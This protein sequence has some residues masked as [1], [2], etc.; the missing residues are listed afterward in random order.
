MKVRTLAIVM[1]ALVIAGSATAQDRS[2]PI[3]ADDLAAI[4]DPQS[5][6]VLQADQIVAILHPVSTR[7]IV[8]DH[9]RAPGDWGSGVLPDLKLR[10]EAGSARLAPSAGA[11]LDELARALNS[12][13]LAEHR[14]EIRGHTD[15]AGGEAMNVE[16]SKARAEAVVGYLAGQRDVDLARLKAVGVGEAELARP[17]QPDSEMNRRVEVRALR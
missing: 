3:D 2:Q 7:S 8:T 12:E 15:A 17:D 10:F 5:D 6:P 13:L 1:A 4:L 9:E 16:L 11:Q 14:F